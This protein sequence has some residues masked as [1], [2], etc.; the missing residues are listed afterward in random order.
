M[1][2]KDNFKRGSLEML[3]LRLLLNHDCY[4]Y[5]LTQLME[6]QSDG[7]IIVPSGSLYP[8]LYK[9]LDRGYISEY[10]IR[11]GKRQERIYYHLEKDGRDYL[12]EQINAYNDISKA[13]AKILAYKGSAENEKE[14][15][16]CKSHK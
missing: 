15:V 9:L 1:K 5:Q 11:I 16:I 10:S 7:Q 2:T 4:G 14:R 12:K 6:E 8:T 13:I 3:I